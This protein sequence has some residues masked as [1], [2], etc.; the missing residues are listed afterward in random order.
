[1]RVLEVS[2][3]GCLVTM[4][5]AVTPG[6]VGELSVYLGDREFR[7]PLRFVRAL[8]RHGSCHVY[9]MGGAFTE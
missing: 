4:N 8:A 7:N 9:T 6:A 1:M 2:V 3:S 5:Q